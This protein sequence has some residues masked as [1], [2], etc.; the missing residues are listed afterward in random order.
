MLVCLGLVAAPAT[1]ILHVLTL[2]SR[3]KDQWLTPKPNVKV[4]RQ[5]NEPQ[6]AQGFC[7]YEWLLLV[8]KC[9]C[10]WVS[11]TSMVKCLEESGG[12]YTVL[13]K[14][15][16]IYSLSFAFPCY[17]EISYVRG[18]MNSCPKFPLNVWSAFWIFIESKLFF[19]HGSYFSSEKVA[20]NICLYFNIF[21]C[22]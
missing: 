10:E 21:S 15:K 14:C 20:I 9:V 6:I 8:Y 19:P 22:L 4:S 7:M 5:D 16:S 13:Y 12:Q 11:L 18:R 2:S 1:L 17:A 3:R